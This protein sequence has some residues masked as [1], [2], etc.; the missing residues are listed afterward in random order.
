MWTRREWLRGRGEVGFWGRWAGSEGG[1]WVPEDKVRAGML[2]LTAK[3]GARWNGRGGRSWLRRP[4]PAG[5]V[6]RTRCLSAGCL[7]RAVSMEGVTSP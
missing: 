7:E 6:A 1:A 3:C 4:R 5:G 2:T